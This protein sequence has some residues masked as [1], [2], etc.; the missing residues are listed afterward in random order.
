MA[1]VVECERAW[2]NASYEGHLGVVQ[3]LLATG[4]DTATQNQHVSSVLFLASVGGHLEVAQA[5][6]A[7]GA[8]TAVQ[9]KNGC[10]ALIWLG[11]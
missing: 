5:L 6:L 1:R 4:A 2:W 8:D 11:E 9:S 7:A 3:A 10:T